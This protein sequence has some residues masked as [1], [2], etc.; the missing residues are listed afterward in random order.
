MPS[1]Q[2]GH[3]LLTP[4]CRARLSRDGCLIWGAFR[5]GNWV[6]EHTF[7]WCDSI[8]Y[9]DDAIISMNVM[10]LEGSPRLAASHPQQ[11]TRPLA[12]MTV[13]PRPH[14]IHTSGYWDASAPRCIVISLG[15][16][17]TSWQLSQHPSRGDCSAGSFQAGQVEPA[18]GRTL[19]RRCPPASHRILHRIGS[20]MERD[21]GWSVG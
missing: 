3:S 10:S 5:S 7:T 9:Q 4:P 16:G 20:H 17:A 14:F 11:A 18:T 21:G 19:G 2:L 15:W 13:S 8:M 1:W 6:A 12:T